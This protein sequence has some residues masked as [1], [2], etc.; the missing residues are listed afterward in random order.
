MK[1]I[2]SKDKKTLKRGFWVIL[3]EL[4]PYSQ[5][6]KY[7]ELIRKLWHYTLHNAKNLTKRDYNELEPSVQRTLGDDNMPTLTQIFYREGMEKGMA[8]GKA[9]GK[10]EAKAE[11]VLLILTKRFQ[12]VPKSLETQLRAVTDLERLE[13]LADFAFDCKSP[14]EFAGKLKRSMAKNKST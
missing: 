4:K 7:Y 11:A 12:S 5:N 6:P 10:A 3:D 13:Q 1:V 9:E 2:F 14:D 8:E